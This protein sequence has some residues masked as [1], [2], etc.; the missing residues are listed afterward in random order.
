MTRTE[1]IASV[2]RLTSLSGSEQE[3]DDLAYQLKLALPY[4]NISD[5]LYY[6]D[7]DRTEEEI[8]DEAIRRE[9]A[10]KVAPKE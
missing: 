3:L 5:M 8:V 1:L 4:G 6:P 2:K 10:H 7:K 9:A